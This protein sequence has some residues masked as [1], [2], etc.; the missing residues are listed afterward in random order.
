[1]YKRKIGGEVLFGGWS[2]SI[3]GIGL[4]S[5]ITVG[6]GH[7]SSTLQVRQKEWKMYGYKD[8]F[9]ILLLIVSKVE[10]Y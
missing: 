10:V 3:I 4:N 6:E 9:D 2:L 5:R 7:L 1:L 8:I